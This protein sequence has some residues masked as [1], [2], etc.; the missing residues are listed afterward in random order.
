MV[1]K[2]ERSKITY[3][4][5]SFRLC[6]DERGNDFQ[7]R[8]YTPLDEDPLKFLEV[9]EVMLLMDKI[10]DRTGYPQSFQEKRSFRKNQIKNEAFHGIPETTMT[11]G[12]MEQN[13][14]RLV[15]LDIMVSSRQNA[16][17]QGMVFLPDGTKFGDFNGE[18][19]LLQLLQNA[20][21]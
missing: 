10:F 7:G 16:S 17:W 12:D 20:M 13:R 21:R 5:N 1:I 3:P 19:D 9:R 18:H 14:G 15:T 4:P 8:V 6:I 2:M 11:Y